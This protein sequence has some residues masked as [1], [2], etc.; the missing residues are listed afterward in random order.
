MMFAD[1]GCVK[2]AVWHFQ[3]QGSPWPSDHVWEGWEGV[4]SKTSMHSSFG[5]YKLL[6]IEMHQELEVRASKMLQVTKCQFE[7]MHVYSA[8]DIAHHTRGWPVFGLGCRTCSSPRTI[9]ATV[10]FNTCDAPQS[11]PMPVIE[12]SWGCIAVGLCLAALLWGCVWLHCR[13]A[14]PGCI[15]VGLCMSGWGCVWLHCRG[16][17]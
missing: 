5:R 17:V 16:A 1:R 11:L 6:C 4:T 7:G 2:A 3:C 12:A 15:A 13:G 14:V 9:T 10:L 8:L